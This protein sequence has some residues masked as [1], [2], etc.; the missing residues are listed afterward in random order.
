MLAWFMNCGTAVLAAA[1]VITAA[2][3]FRRFFKSRSRRSI[4]LALLSLV[5][6]IAMVIANFPFNFLA[7]HAANKR[8]LQTMVSRIKD[9]DI[10]GKPRDYIAETYGRPGPWSRNTKGETETWS[11]SPG[12]LLS[13]GSMDSVEIE[14]QNG[15]VTRWY[16]DWF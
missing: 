8:A 13:Y 6:A 3:S 4:L 11:Y 15:T 7:F 5:F 2:L 9:D 16:I 10:E 1:G 14:F 12:P